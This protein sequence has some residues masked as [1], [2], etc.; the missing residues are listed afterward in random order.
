MYLPAGGN[1]I[2]LSVYGNSNSSDQWTELERF[3]G[4]HGDEWIPFRVDVPSMNPR[5]ISNLAF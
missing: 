5:V 1:E 3:T 4:N 2:S